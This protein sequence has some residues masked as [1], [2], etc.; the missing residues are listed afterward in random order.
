MKIAF[1]NPP[2]KGR[3]SRTSRSPAVTSGG[4]LYYPFWLAYAAGVAENAGHEIQ[5]TDSPADGLS[6]EQTL[7]KIKSFKPGL[8]VLD[9]STPSIYSDVKVAEAIKKDVPD[10]FIVLVGT[11]P[12]ALPEET[13][14]LSDN[15]DAIAI[16][17]YDYIIRDLAD[18][19]A[20]NGSVNDVTGLALQQN[21]NIT[22]TGPREKI[23]NLDELPFVSSVYKKYFNHR[24]YFF[25]AAKYP[26]IM[27]ITGRGCPFQCFFCVYPQTFHS[28]RYRAR[29][30]EN[31]VAEFEYI[32]ENFPDVKEIGIEDDCFAANPKRV[33]R[34]CELLIE[35]KVNMTWYCNVRGDVDYETLKLMRRAGCRLVTV[36]FESADQNTLDLMHKSEKIEK[37]YKFAEDARRAKIMVHGCIMCGTPGDSKEIQEKNYQFAVKINCDSMQFYPLYVYPGTEAYEWAKEKGYLITEDY[38]K[39]LKDNGSHNCVTNIEGMTADEMVALCEANL[40]RYHLRPRYLLMKLGQA[41]RDPAEGWRSIK[42][43]W[44]LVKKI[45]ARQ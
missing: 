42:S 30:P 9:T 27:I 38:S 31:V 12:S 2:F 32:K 33:Q 8:A 13:L 19:I 20:G 11:H 1:L 22:R 28:R 43:G 35:R 4:T 17:E 34:I 15:L 41:F 10:C 6:L 16:G 39:W 7:E 44:T 26:M 37:Y 3:F 29:S 45:A 40:K 36:G 18:A 5:L 21:G 25:A 14:Q 23:E 24:N